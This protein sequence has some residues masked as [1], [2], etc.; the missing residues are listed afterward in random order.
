M[1]VL[2]YTTGI[3]GFSF[4]ITGSNTSKSGTVLLYT[5]GT[6]PRVAEEQILPENSS[7]LAN[8]N[9][10]RALSVTLSVVKGGDSDRDEDEFIFKF[11]LEQFS[12]YSTAE[13]TLNKLINRPM[14]HERQEGTLHEFRYLLYIDR[15]PKIQLSFP[16]WRRVRILPP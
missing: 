3:R 7:N 15:S 14:N 12:S 16:V 1:R 13:T 2:S 4:H 6:R 5:S 9:R 11:V 10:P 8:R